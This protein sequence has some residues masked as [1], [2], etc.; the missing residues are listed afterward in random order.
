MNVLLKELE[1]LDRAVPYAPEFVGSVMGRLPE[2]ASVAN[3]SWRQPR[4]LTL[5]T[6]GA[7][8]ATILIG[9]IIFVLSPS[10]QVAFGQMVQRVAQFDSVRYDLHYD[11]GGRMDCDHRTSSSDGRRRSEFVGPAHIIIHNPKTSPELDLSLRPD[12]KL[13]QFWLVDAF[14]EAH[15]DGRHSNDPIVYLQQIAAENV[16]SAPDEIYRDKPVRVFISKPGTTD[17]KRTIRVLVDKDSGMP[18]RIETLHD[19]TSAGRGIAHRVFDNFEWNPPI[20]ESTYSTVPPAGYAVTYN[21]IRPLSMGLDQYSAFF[22][23]QLPDHVDA[24]ALEKLKEKVK[25]LPNPTKE[26]IDM[27]IAD[28]VWGF[29]VP[30][31]AAAHN[32]DFRYYGA[33][34]SYSSKG[35]LR[36]IAAVEIAPGSGIYDCMMSPPSFERVGRTKLP[37]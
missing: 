21:L 35:P 11:D 22:N 13:A 25:S 9:T 20:D 5:V 10:P 17:L 28:A 12:L 23:G 33:G 6:I 7:M 34:Q 16:I 36:M 3:S 29:R 37:H 4:T 2:V 31:F 24:A 32:L 19:M 8:A 30:A 18:L 27:T 26:D 15:T 14:R 1:Q